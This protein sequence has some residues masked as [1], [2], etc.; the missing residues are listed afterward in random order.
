MSELAWYCL[1]TKPKTEHIAAAMLT[2]LLGV[3]TYCPRL[4]YQKSTARG[5]VWFIEAL[6]PRY[7]FAR[8]DMELMSRA[9]KHSMHV[10]R[11]VE[12]NDKPTPI[13]DEVIAELRAEMEFQDVVEIHRSIEVGDEVELTDGP[14]RGLK[15]VVQTVLSGQDRVRVLLEF[16]GRQNAVELEVGKLLADRSARGEYAWQRYGEG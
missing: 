16:L 11:I 14:M 4:R 7:V 2:S 10:V 3:E 1:H 12:F 8:F 6:F 15:G 9:V 5:K 13:A